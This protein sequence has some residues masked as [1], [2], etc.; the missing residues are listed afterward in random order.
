MGER[1]VHRGRSESG[2]LDQRGC[3]RDGLALQRLVHRESRGGCAPEA[4]DLITIGV[5]ERQQRVRRRHRL[6]RA[7]LDSLREEIQPT[8]P[9]TAQAHLIQ[10]LVVKRSVPL[11]VETRIE[12][13]LA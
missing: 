7:R 6:R 2:G 9:V 3:G 13:R 12:H 8:L 11:E 4:G 5:N 1:F 10:Q